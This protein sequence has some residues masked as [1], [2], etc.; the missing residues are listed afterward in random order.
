MDYNAVNLNLCVVK[1]VF[2]ECEQSVFYDVLI[3]SF[4]A[5]ALAM[6]EQVWQIY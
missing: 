2:F 4:I 3:H 1:V 5:N 6:V